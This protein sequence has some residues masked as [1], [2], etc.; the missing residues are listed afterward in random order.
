M[1]AANI[2]LIV[3]F[4]LPA[5]E[6]APLAPAEQQGPKVELSRA[7]DRADELHC[8]AYRRPAFPGIAMQAESLRSSRTEAPKRRKTTFQSPPQTHQ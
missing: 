1:P 3:K 8:Q 4:R 2:P 5:L 6:C 7:A